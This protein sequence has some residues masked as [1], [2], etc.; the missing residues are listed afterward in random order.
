MLGMFEYLTLQALS[1][2]VSAIFAGW[3]VLLHGGVV[4]SGDGAPLKEAQLV[5]VSRYGHILV[6]WTPLGY[7]GRLSMFRVV[8]GQTHISLPGL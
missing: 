1:F 6:A 3:G 2:I 8:L 5:G 7:S 4:T